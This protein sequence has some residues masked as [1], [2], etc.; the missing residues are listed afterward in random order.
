MD[1]SFS[2]SV[3]GLKPSAIREILKFTSVPGYVPFAAGNPAP[4]ALP[5]EAVAK[6]AADIMS[7]TPVA[8]LQYSVTEGY[9]P[10]RDH[11]KEYMKEKHNVGTTDDELIITSGAQ[12]VMNLSA[13]V[14][15]NVGDS[16]ICE[17]PSFI[18]S[19]N[20]FRSF[21]LNLVGVD[22]DD[23]GMNI[24]KLEAAL[25]ANPNA[26]FIYTIPT[27]QNPS[28]VCMSLAKRKAVYELAKKYQILILEDN[29]YSDTRFAGKELPTIKSF[30]TDGLVIYAGTFSKV[31]SPGLRVGYAIAPK[32]IISKMVVCKQTSDVHTSI[33][34]QMICHEFMTKYD[35]EEHL[36]R[37]RVIYRK[38]CD[39]MTYLMDKNIGDKISYI[40]PEGGLFI[41]VKLPDSVDMTAFCTRAVEKKVATVPGTA[42]T[43]DPSELSHCFRINYST[44]TD[45]QIVKGITVLGQVANEFIK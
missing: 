39:L 38:K 16:V 43:T 40:K 31:I 2:S 22:M 42:F 26:K 35:Y 10:L 20:A 1:Y 19:L 41:W 17:N 15:C 33:F 6:I 32:E 13:M 29:P 25:K 36:D 28:G 34:S 14:L 30:D 12:Q 3:A 11:L 18:G 44:P 9:T 8:A 45:E 23:D 7:E 5:T 37:N 21:G 27:F 4:E 24:E